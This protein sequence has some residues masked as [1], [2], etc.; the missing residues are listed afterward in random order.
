MSLCDKVE[1]LALAI[2]ERGEGL[3]WGPYWGRGREEGEYAGCDSRAEDRLAS[4][5]CPDRG[6]H[7]LLVGI[8]EDVAACSCPQGHEH[9]VLILE[10][11][12]HQDA[13]ARALLEDPSCG[14]YAVHL[15]HLQVHQDHIG[16]KLF[17]THYGLFA[18]CCLAYYLEI[19]YRCEQGDHALAEER[20]VFGDEDLQ[21]LQL[22]HSLGLS[23]GSGRR[24]STRVPPSEA[25]STTQLPPSSDAR[26]RIEESP[27]P[28]LRSAGMPTPSST[29]SSSNSS[30]TASRTTYDL[31]LA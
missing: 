14:L 29:I 25:R 28:A 7:L 21:G 5:H 19:G 17:G 12:Y 15:W 18:C 1:Y 10:E 3:R 26:S 30:L 22:S 24:T 16:L 23:L 2:G 4:A 6:Q 13:H 27:T 20:V 11:R 31:A 9:R 8:F